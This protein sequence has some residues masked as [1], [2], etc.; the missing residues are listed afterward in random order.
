MTLYTNYA[1]EMNRQIR[2]TCVQSI[3]GLEKEMDTLQ[4][5]YTSK[6]TELETRIAICQDAINKIDSIGG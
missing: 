2:A 1:R 6:R 4:T 3:A 5:A